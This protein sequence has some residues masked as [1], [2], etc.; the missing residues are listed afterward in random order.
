M[1]LGGKLIKLG[2]MK[3][4]SAFDVRERPPFNVGTGEVASNSTHSDGPSLSL[5]RCLGETLDWRPAPH[6]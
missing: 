3:G 1:A 5:T 6:F 4:T 2:A